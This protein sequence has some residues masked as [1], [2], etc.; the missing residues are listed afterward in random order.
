[1]ADILD[2]MHEASDTAFVAGVPLIISHHKCAGPANWGRTLQT[3]P[4]IDRLAE[5]QE[6]ALD[7]YPYVAGSTVLREDLVDEVIDVLVSWSAPYPEAT[8]RLL[9]AIAE[10]WGVTQREACVRLKPGGACYFQMHEDD[11][12]RVLSHRRSFIGSDGLPH[13]KHPHPRLWGAFPRVLSRYWRDEQLF[14]L[15]QAVR[16]MTGLTAR[17]FRLSERGELRSGWFADLAVF[18]PQ[19]VRDLA[20]YKEPLQRSEGI[21]RVYVNGQLA[22]TARD[23][24]CR[25]RAGKVLGRATV[26]AH[27]RL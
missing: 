16:K 3:L 14:T 18:D 10:E 20:T 2:A 15:E 27:K 24:V 6:I 22:L 12:R 17:H 19:R 21:E 5:R 25:H 13:D 4:L 11:V 8:G 7:V 26:A 1:M 9:S 23:S